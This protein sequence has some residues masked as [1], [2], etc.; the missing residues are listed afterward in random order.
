VNDRVFLKKKGKII[1]RLLKRGSWSSQ[2]KSN[3]PVRDSHPLDVI[4]FKAELHH[5]DYDRPS[6][7]ELYLYHEAGENTE[8]EESLIWYESYETLTYSCSLELDYKPEN[9]D[10]V[11]KLITLVNGHLLTGHFDFIEEDKLLTFRYAMLLH[12]AVGIS[13]HQCAALLDMGPKI[14]STH[15]QAFQLVG[16]THLSAQDALEI[17]TF[18]VHGRA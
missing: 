14:Y 12:G 15:H 8:Y 9:R 3:M 16:T 5:L 2:Y 1:L 4:E 7:D 11:R 18:E 10:E 6:A 13:S 17:A